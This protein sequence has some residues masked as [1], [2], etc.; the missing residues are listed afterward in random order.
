MKKCG[1]EFIVIEYNED[2]SALLVNPEGDIITLSLD[3]F[4]DPTFQNESILLGEGRLNQAQFSKYDQFNKSRSA[5]PVER[6]LEDFEELST[7]D[8]L[9]ILEKIS[10]NLCQI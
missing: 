5:S 8:Q 1:K 3:L 9:V 7:H 4:Y 6:F 10:T 2:D